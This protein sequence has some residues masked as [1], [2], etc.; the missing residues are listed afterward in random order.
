[1]N[2]EGF[3]QVS[4]YELI[5]NDKESYYFPTTDF[6]SGVVWTPALPLKLFIFGLPPL[7]AKCT[8]HTPESVVSKQVGSK[9]RQVISFEPVCRWEG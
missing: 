4:I 1:M 3:E 7:L 6:V 2:H 5:N 8:I 9:F